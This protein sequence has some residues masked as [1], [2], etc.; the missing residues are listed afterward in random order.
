VPLLQP[1]GAARSGPGPGAS[2]APIGGPR[3]ELVVD[4][5]LE[6]PRQ[7]REAVQRWAHASG[8]GHL[9]DDLVL[10]VSELVTNAVR[11]GAPPVRLVVA[12]DDRTVTVTVVDGD[13][14]QPDPR[15]PALDAEGGRGLLL[16]DLLA[17]E[18][19]VEPAPPGKAVWA[20]LPRS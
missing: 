20:A 1:P 4:A 19:G 5:G 13:P 9:C 11:H 8:A 17:A 15:V 2:A 3:T 7:A 18:H 14:G 10:I 6:G 12:A 16:I